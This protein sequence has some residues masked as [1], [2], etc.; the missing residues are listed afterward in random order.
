[1]ELKSNRIFQSMSRKEKLGWMSPAK[2]WLT[3][4]AAQKQRNSRNNCYA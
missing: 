4:L 1:M 2:Y 3:S